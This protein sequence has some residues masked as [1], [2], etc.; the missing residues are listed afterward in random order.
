MSNDE[1]PPTGNPFQSPSEPPTTK[2]PAQSNEI[3]WTLAGCL[4]FVWLLFTRSSPPLGIL[5][6]ASVLVPGL[7]NAVIDFRRQCRTGTVGPW[8]QWKTIMF[9]FL[10]LIPLIILAGA[11]LMGVAVVTILRAEATRQVA[12]N[13]LNVYASYVVGLIAAVIVYAGEVI[14]LLVWKTLRHQKRM[15]RAATRAD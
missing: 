11:T 10:Q 13:S 6:G 3:F 8:Q 1:T 14:I 2:T 15:E 9:A 7:L 5:V 12:S 4:V